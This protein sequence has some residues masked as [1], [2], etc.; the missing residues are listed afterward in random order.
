MIAWMNVLRKEKKK[1]K[2]KSKVSCLFQGSNIH[3]PKLLFSSLAATH[4]HLQF[5]SKTDNAVDK[6]LKTV[7]IFKR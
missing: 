2:E 7:Q 5:N 4:N 1:K 3:I 6:T